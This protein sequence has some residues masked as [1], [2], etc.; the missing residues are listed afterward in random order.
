MYLAGW[1]AVRCCSQQAPGSRA[2]HYS[3]QCCTSCRP[4][5]LLLLLLLR[6]LR[7]GCSVGKQLIII[8]QAVPLPLF[9][10]PGTLVQG[11]HI[12]DI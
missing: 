4:L 12:P 11:L 10:R 8:A 6:L 3:R 2:V 9:L 5:L 1:R 7:H